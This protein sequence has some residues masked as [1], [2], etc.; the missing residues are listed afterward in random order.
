[1]NLKPSLLL[2]RRTRLSLEEHKSLAFIVGRDPIL[3]RMDDTDITLQHGWSETAA[4]RTGSASF[5]PS[6]LSSSY[7][8]FTATSASISPSA[9]AER[10]AAASTGPAPRK[11]LRDF[12][13]LEPS[14]SDAK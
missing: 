2:D 6:A 5:G 12:K 1:M 13:A 4:V 11:C 10:H 7:N 3:F 8:A 9:T 14:A